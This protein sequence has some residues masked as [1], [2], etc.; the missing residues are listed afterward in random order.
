[1]LVDL[2]LSKI[3]FWTKTQV[4]RLQNQ[5]KFPLCV[6]LNK[7]TWMIGP[8]KIVE[9]GDKQF[10]LSTNNQIINVFFSKKAAIFY[11][12]LQISNSQRRIK[13]AT[14]LLE[15]DIIVGKLYNKMLFYHKKLKHNKSKSNDFKQQL[16]QVRLNE[17]KLNLQAANKDLLKKL[18]HAK[19]IKVWENENELKRYNT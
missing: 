9:L 10:K 15:N 19:Y 3:N 13:L 4:N 6:A 1:M 18:N 8:Y 12:V 2:A 5:N 16:W 14:E 17:V 11:A 7:H